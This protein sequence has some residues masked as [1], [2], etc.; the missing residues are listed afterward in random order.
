MLDC[1]AK[2]SNRVSLCSKKFLIFSKSLI[3]RFEL[4]PV[5]PTFSTLGRFRIDFSWTVFFMFN[6]SFWSYEKDFSSKN[7]WFFLNLQLIGATFFIQ[8]SLTKLN[9][10]WLL[11]CDQTINDICHD[12]S[13]QQSSTNLETTIV[14]CY[15]FK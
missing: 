11:S 13:W 14:N 6:K 9:M 1:G 4:C 8:S 7:F 12:I 2:L 5:L 15:M 3:K 10:L